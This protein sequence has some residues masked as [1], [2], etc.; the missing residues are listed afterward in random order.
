MTSVCIALLFLF[1]HLLLIVVPLCLYRSKRAF[2][3]KFYLAMLCSENARRLYARVLLILLL[4]F[5]Y[6]YVCGHPGDYGTVVSTILLAVMFSTRRTMRWMSR[7]HDERNV[8]CAVALV[9]VALAAVPHLYTTAMTLAFL[10][11]AAAFYPS[12]WAMAKWHDRQTRHYWKEFP[13]VLYSCY[14]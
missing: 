7:L 8:F 13:E 9:A 14:F 10:L 11:L 6:V 5:H 3:A 4:V 2:M 1:F 12:I